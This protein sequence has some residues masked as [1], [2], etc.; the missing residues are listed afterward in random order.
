AGSVAHV[1]VAGPAKPVS[2]AG[3]GAAADGNAG[4]S[5]A[6][7]PAVPATRA[8]RGD[9]VI[10]IPSFVGKL[11]IRIDCRKK[12]SRICASMARILQELPRDETFLHRPPGIAA[13]R[14]RIEA[15]AGTT[16]G[17]VWVRFC[18]LGET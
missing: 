2:V 17:R 1:A 4:T 7:R 13:R 9:R 15:T 11:A 14:A 12:A 8:A 6:A 5:S 16:A 3:C 10:A 18:T